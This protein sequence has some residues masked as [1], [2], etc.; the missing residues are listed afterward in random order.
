M[1]DATFRAF[2]VCAVIA[3]ALTTASVA[4]AFVNDPISVDNW[5]SPPVGG[6][7]V[8]GVLVGSCALPSDAFSDVNPTVLDDPDAAILGRIWEDTEV[9]PDAWWVP[10]LKTITLGT[11]AFAAGWG[12]G[13]FINTKWLHI[14]G[15]GLGVATPQIP[16]PYWTQTNSCRAQSFRSG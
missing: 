6:C 4:G 11:A 9:I 7:S 13:S 8:S 3:V 15:A 1:Q 5:N 2:A 10:G 14:D 12:I 16:N